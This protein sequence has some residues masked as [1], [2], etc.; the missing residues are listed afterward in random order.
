[1]RQRLR[2]FRQDADAAIRALG[3]PTVWM[4]RLREIEAAVER[5]EA[6]LDAAYRE[7]PRSEWTQVART[8][9]FSDVNAL[10][11]AHNRYFPVESRL[12][13]DPRTRDFVKINGR[14]YTR[15]PLDADWIL[16]RWPAA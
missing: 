15:P 7:T 11:A 4:R 2:N 14:P 12:P 5:H 6:E 8:W 1:M 3:G 10:I 16:A 9:D 13:M